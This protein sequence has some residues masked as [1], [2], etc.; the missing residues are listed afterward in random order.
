MI[1]HIIKQT[2]WKDIINIKE[3]EVKI[4]LA[5]TI[6]VMLVLH[7]LKFYDLFDEYKELLQELFRGYITSFF[8]MLRFVLAGFA[9]I[10]G[11]FGDAISKTDIKEPEKILFTILARLKFSALSI[12]FLIIYLSVIKFVIQS[13]VIQLERIP[14]ILA[15]SLTNNLVFFNIFYVISLV[16][17]GMKFSGLSP[18]KYSRE[19]DNPNAEKDLKEMIEKNVKNQ[20]TEGRENTADEEVENEDNK[21]KND[22]NH[23]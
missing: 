22:E 8:G 6:I 5:L 3:W 18:N 9:V 21:N 7:Q 2:V 19:S 23:K 12:T 10:I 11:L 16:G 17:S 13:T 1:K 20:E 4:S 14:F 15:L